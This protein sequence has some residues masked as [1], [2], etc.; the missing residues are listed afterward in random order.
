[1]CILQ[2]LEFQFTWPVLT[3]IHTPWSRVL[4]EMLTDF[5]LAKKFHAF[6]ETR[7]FIITSARQLSLSWASS[8]QSISPTSY[9]LKIHLII[10]LPSTPGSPKWSLSFRCHHQN[11]VYASPPYVLNSPPISFFSILS[12][13][14]YWVSSTD[15]SAPRYVVSLLTSLNE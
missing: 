10:I 3:Y 11:P 12:P 13:E 1:M 15:H 14:Q 2:S 8:N 9:F 4:L 5:Q 7:R 6:Y